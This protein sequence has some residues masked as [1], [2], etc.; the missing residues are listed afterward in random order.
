MTEEGY[1]HLVV[2]TSELKQAYAL[3]FNLK[4]LLPYIRKWK[5]NRQ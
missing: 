2:E 1:R 4:K 5:G 3:Q